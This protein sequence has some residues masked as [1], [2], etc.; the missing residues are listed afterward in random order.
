MILRVLALAFALL[1]GALVV[2]P[3]AR[4]QSVPPTGSTQN[5]TSAA[6][7][8]TWTLSPG[9]ATC[10]FGV[11]GTWSGTLTFTI[12]VDESNFAASP[13]D[14]TNT[15]TSNGLVSVTCASAKQV[16]VAES[17]ISGTAVVTMLGTG[18]PAGKANVTVGGVSI[19][20]P[21]PLPVSTINPSLPAPQVTWPV[22][23][24][25]PAPTDAQG[26]VSVT[27]PAPA[28]TNASSQLVVARATAPAFS[29]FHDT[30]LLSS[31][32]AT[33]APAFTLTAGVIAGLTIS[34]ATTSGL[35]SVQVALSA[36][37]TC[38]TQVQSFGR[39]VTG[40]NGTS[41]AIFPPLNAF[42]AFTATNQY[43]CVYG[44]GTGASYDAVIYMQ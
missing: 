9:Q 5:I 3:I 21:I 20:S 29:N 8:Y 34:G 2:A 36:S 18:A 39:I 33:P 43:L 22:T 31:V 12:S 10:L 19:T 44:T 1:T 27:T 14:S 26:R 37:S 25:A 13:S 15:T 35:G 38:A 4:A 32:S 40:P 7:S 17:G 23:T 16:R 6:P 24:P 28:A 30:G 11:A 41:I 42:Q